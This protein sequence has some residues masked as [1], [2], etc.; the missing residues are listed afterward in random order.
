VRDDLRSLL[1]FVDGLGSGSDDPACNPIPAAAPELHRLMGR[2]AVQID[3]RLGVPG[4]PQSATGQTAL[5]TG[6]NAPAAMSRHIEGFPGPGLCRIIKERNVFS[7]FLARGLTATFANGYYLENSHEARRLRLRSVTTV[8]TLSAFGDVRDRAT[9]LAGRA[10]CQ[11]L[12]RQSLRQRGY[13]GPLITP[14]LAADHLL[15]IADNHHFTLFEYFQTD[16]AGHSRDRERVAAVLTDLD[17]FV[18]RIEQ[19]AS[20]HR[21]LV[22]LTSDHGNIE[23]ISTR[24][25]TLNPVPLVAFGP[26]A[27]QLQA[28]VRS[29]VDVVP[30]LLALYDGTLESFTPAPVLPVQEAPA[31]SPEASDHE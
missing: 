12:T 29:L 31:S 10:V 8:A 24:Q 15:A 22:M 27:H 23:D 7:Q 13:E 6:V 14:A 28:A 30:A 3:A 9:L 20:H 21:M 26:H 16:R 1:I 2:H 5:L 19:F 18:T 17:A 25:H 4:L 11:D